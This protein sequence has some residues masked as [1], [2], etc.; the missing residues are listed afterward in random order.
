VKSRLLYRFSV[1]DNVQTDGGLKVI[2]H[3]EQAGGLSEALKEML[4]ENG[5]P[6]A[7]LRKFL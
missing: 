4:L 2:G 7:A 5:A 1:E 6:L 3:F